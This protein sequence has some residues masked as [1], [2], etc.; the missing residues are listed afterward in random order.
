LVFS[1]RLRSNMQ[2]IEHLG[3]SGLVSWST[4]REDTYGCSGNGLHEQRGNDCQHRCDV[5][6]GL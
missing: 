1:L 5:G 4:K 2:S 6:I 3:V